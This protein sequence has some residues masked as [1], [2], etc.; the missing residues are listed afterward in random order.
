MMDV[1]AVMVVNYTARSWSLQRGEFL[2]LCSPWELCLKLI[3]FSINLQLFCFGAFIVSQF[4]LNGTHTNESE[5]AAPLGHRCPLLFCH[6]DRGGRSTCA[7][8]VGGRDETLTACLTACLLCNATWQNLQAPIIIN[9]C[10]NV[11]QLYWLRWEQHRRKD[12]RWVGSD[13][14]LCTDWQPE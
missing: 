14:L 11:W 13:K 2:C 9:A 3:S 4:F 7:V 10:V 12:K 1:D 8:Y 6:R 5:S